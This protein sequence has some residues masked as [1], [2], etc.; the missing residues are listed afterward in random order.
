MNG[1][2]RQAKWT[3]LIGA[4]VGLAVAAA[5][6]VVLRTNTTG[7]QGSAP[8]E[9]FVY[10]LKP[11][12]KTDPKLVLYEET[13]T[14]TTGFKEP[15]AVAVDGEGRVYVAG[16]KAVS[17]FRGHDA[18]VADFRRIALG[19][20]PHCLAIANGGTLY[21]G[22]NQHVEVYDAK[23]E[24]KAVWESLGDDAVLTSIAVAGGDVFVAD[25]GNRV[26][27]RYDTSGKVLGRIGRKDESRNI[28][29]LL[30]PSPY[31]D[32]AIG[33][34]GLLW[35]ANP[36]RFRLEAYTAGGDLE[37]WWG[38]SSSSQIEGF[39]GC[40]NPSNFA[41]LPD[42]K[43]VTAEEGL[44]RVKI[45]KADGTFEG[46]VAGTESFAE[47]TVGLDVAADSHGCILVLDPPRRIVHI[48]T[49]IGK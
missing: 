23:G 14:I 16:D 17:V 2:A 11:L 28:S 41:I 40:C 35:V 6:V 25:A 26:V 9:G 37:I 4:G 48:Y 38:K 1:R 19:A 15:R 39:C 7:E 49:R 45:Y 34:E 30:V 36:G 29:G 5:I 27:V 42:G 21:I 46:V 31:L 8:D 10:D 43:F 3:L 20:S 32:V 12:A 22:M 24:R 13:G 33:R 44:P 47:G 18:D